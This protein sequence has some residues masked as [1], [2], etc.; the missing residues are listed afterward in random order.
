MALAGESEESIDL[1]V[2]DAEKIVAAHIGHRISMKRMR[3]KVTQGR[4]IGNGTICSDLEKALTAVPQPI[5]TR[6]AKS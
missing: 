4:K 2:F 1:S 3:M 5:S 6:H